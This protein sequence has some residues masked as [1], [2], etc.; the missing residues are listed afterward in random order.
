MSDHS[1]ELSAG[2]IAYTGFGTDAIPGHHPERIA[3]PAVRAQVVAIMQ[4]VNAIRPGDD[5]RDLF[6]W[7]ERQ[8]TIVGERHPELSE[9]ALDAVRALLTFEWR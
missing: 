4:E 8:R 7:G 3:D 2:V 9:R 5:A 1:N 6:A